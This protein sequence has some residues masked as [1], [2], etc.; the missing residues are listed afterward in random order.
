MP[1][2]S[3]RSQIWRLLRY[4]SFTKLSPLK[5]KCILENRPCNLNF[6]EMEISIDL[7]ILKFIKYKKINKN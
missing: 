1:A 7:Q 4:F 6:I 5:L 3:Y 2:Y